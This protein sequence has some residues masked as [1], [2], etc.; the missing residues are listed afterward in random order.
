[1]RF[2]LLY[3][4]PPHSFL[5]REIFW[6]MENFASAQKAR[7]AAASRSLKTAASPK[8]SEAEINRLKTRNCGKP[9]TRREKTEGRQKLF[10]GILLRASRRSLLNKKKPGSLRLRKLNHGENIFPAI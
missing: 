4:T 8:F 7:P 3:I 5:S 1:M 9:I 10:D 6:Q 2:F